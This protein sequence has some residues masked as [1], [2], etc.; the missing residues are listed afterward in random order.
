[1]IS[2]SNRNIITFHVCYLEHKVIAPCIIE[3]IVVYVCDLYV[4]VHI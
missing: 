2:D 4:F 1:M 3:I